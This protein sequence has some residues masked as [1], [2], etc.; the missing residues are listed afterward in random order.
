MYEDYQEFKTVIVQHFQQHEFD[1]IIELAT[2]HQAKFLA[3]AHIILANAFINRAVYQRATPN[4]D[5]FMESFTH[6]FLAKFYSKDSVDLFLDNDVKFS[7]DAAEKFIKENV[8]KFKVQLSKE[9]WEQIIKKA[10]DFYKAH[11]VI[12]AIKVGI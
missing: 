7:A 10:D 9:E 4:K 3:L 11:P 6:I 12:E 2:I 8:V 5:D 1:R